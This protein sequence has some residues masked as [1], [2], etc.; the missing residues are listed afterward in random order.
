MANKLNLSQS[1]K[2][3]LS[4]WGSILL[5]IVLILFI[6]N[7]FFPIE[8][9][10][11]Q[12][13][14]KKNDSIGPNGEVTNYSRYSTVTSTIDKFY[15]FINSD[16]YDAVLKIL[17]EKYVTENNI[18]KDNVDD[19]IKFDDKALAFDANVMY[20]LYGKKGVYEYY[21]DGNLIYA[22]TGEVIE[23]VYYSVILDGNTLLFSIKPITAEEYSKEAK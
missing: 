10:V 9:L 5:G 16:N 13:V 2:K 14:G 3:V 1:E 18:T 8:S 4:I 22:N 15:A 6:I 20:Q 19:Y 21:V 17:N 23:K 11:S 12:M 7:I